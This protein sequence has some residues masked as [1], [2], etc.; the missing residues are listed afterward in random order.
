[1]L[2]PLARDLMIL[3]LWRSSWHLV[4]S[5]KIEHHFQLKS[6]HRLKTR[7]FWK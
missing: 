3:I 1:M 2:R 6:P 7:G 4:Q 5:E